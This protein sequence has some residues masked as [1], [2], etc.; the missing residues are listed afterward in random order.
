M[1]LLKE[2][3]PRSRCGSRRPWRRRDRSAARC[4]RTSPS[5]SGREEDRLILN[6]L[7]STGILAGG[8]AHDFNNL[9]T[10]ILLDLELAQA[11]SILPARNCTRFLEEAKKAALTARDLTQ[12][13]ITFAKG[14]A[15][16]PEADPP[17]RRDP[18]IRPVGLER[19]PGAAA[20]SR[21][22]RISGQRRWTRAR[23]DKSSAT[24]S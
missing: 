7:E 20:N 10:V 24:W 15:P 12:Q 18:G 2:G 14:G 5:T 6:K 9:L 21:W 17:A 19:F 16:S 8:I 1:T 22:P 23:S 13:L 3:S 4:L 11:C